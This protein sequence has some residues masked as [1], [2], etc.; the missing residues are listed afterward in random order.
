MKSAHP[1]SLSPASNA[2]V[3]TRA[4]TK[5]AKPF[6]LRNRLRWGFLRSKVHVSAH[7][8]R[9]EWLLLGLLLLCYTYF[10]LTPSTNILSRYDMVEAL[11]HGTAIIDPYLLTPDATCA[12]PSSPAA[13]AI[14]MPTV[15]TN[16]AQQ[17]CGN[18]HYSC[19]TIDVS[20]YRNH[21]YSP[22]SLGLSLLAVPPY[23][24]LLGLA[25]LFHV[26]LDPTITIAV[27]SLVTIAPCTLLAALL[28]ARMVRWLR[29]SL[30]Q[31]AFPLL[32][33]SAYA[34]GTLAY[35]FSVAFLS[36]QVGGALML[37]AFYLL[38][39]ARQAGMQVGR[40]LLILGGL[41][42]GIAVISEY[43]TGSIALLLA[44]YVLWVFPGQ[45]LRSLCL[46]LASLLPVGGA[47]LVYNSLAFGNP[48]SLSYGFVAGQEFAGQHQG[49]FGVTLPRLDALATLL[50]SPRGL[51]V[52]SPFL[53]LVPLGLYWWWKH[54][55]Q[56][57]A[58]AALCGA[59]SLI[60]LLWNASY[61][62]PMGGYAVPGP[63]FLVPMLPFACLPLA[64]CADHLRW[65]FT[66]LFAFAVI[67]SFLYVAGDVRII[68]DYGAYPFTN[69]WLPLLATG[70]VDPHNGPTPLNLGHDL[71]GLP[72][73][74]GL[75][76][77]L[78]PLLVWLV[79]L[80]YQALVVIPRSSARV[81]SE[82][83]FPRQKASAS[84]PRS[85]E[86][87]TGFTA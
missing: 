17:A 38:W 65:L 84:V 11:G 56:W 70:Q 53:L 32:I 69:L 6:R 8:S 76:P 66:P 51:L 14:C 43:P 27:L 22:R 72:P 26:T 13:S 60:Y 87:F 61:F 52:E 54:A 79:W 28:M 85:D 67:I 7:L 44:G 64:F 49:F 20:Y 47:L 86:R 33:T 81:A 41:S 23:L 75:Y 71:L 10:Q 24:L 9:T 4:L 80:C 31:S 48:F 74:L 40:T 82:A 30:A 68:P 18:A 37:V 25:M 35:P 39:R 77:L 46:F 29:P 12:M 2:Q 55:P 58:E 62:L 1:S 36:H 5:P 3:S 15:F 78:L 16:D 59:I 50:I 21:Y 42:A 45:R 83:A 34:L 73:S 63:R 19:N 57:R